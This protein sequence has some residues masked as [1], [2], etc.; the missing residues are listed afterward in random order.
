MR[1][2]GRLIGGEG[3]QVFCGAGMRHR[4]ANL[5]PAHRSAGGHGQ[6]VDLAAREAQSAAL[7]IVGSFG[8]AEDA[9][10]AVEAQG[11]GGVE[12]GGE[13]GWGGDGDL[14]AG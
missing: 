3:D 12:E 7:D 11:A 2:V 14:V 10:L 1:I 8:E 5:V 13:W 9:A 4:L 6:S